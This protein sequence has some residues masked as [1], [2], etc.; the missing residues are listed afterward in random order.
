M[1]QRSESMPHPLQWEFPGGK[2]LRDESASDA[3]QREMLEELDLEV[4]PLQEGPTVFW[5]Y[6]HKKIA[7]VPVKCEIRS[8]KLRLREHVKSGWLS[9]EEMN[10]MNVLEADLLIIKQLEMHS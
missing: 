9:L 5:E 6:P 1:V 8:G 4:A 10:G 3:I 7:L 2:L